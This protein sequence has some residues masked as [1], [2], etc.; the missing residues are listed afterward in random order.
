M[1][2]LR[3]AQR[4]S[5]LCHQQNSQADF[6]GEAIGGPCALRL[7]V[8]ETEVTFEH[9]KETFNVP[10]P[11]CPECSGLQQP[12]DWPILTKKR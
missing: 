2:K 8:I 1:N 3:T 6:N 5:Q 9:G 7:H 10:P 12:Q 4:V 11:V